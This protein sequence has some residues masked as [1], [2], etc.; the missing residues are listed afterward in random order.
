MTLAGGTSGVILSAAGAGL[1]ALWED[2]TVP[3]AV[4]LGGVS[5][6]YALHELE[7]IRLPVPGRDWQVPADWVRNGFY[8]SAVIFGGT[9]GFGVFTRV[10][11]AS[12]PI[13]FAWLFVS[14]NIAYG[15]LAGLVYGAMRAVSIYASTATEGPEELVTLNRTIMRLA[16][17]AHQLTGLMLAAFAGY[18][19][20]GPYL[21]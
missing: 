21:A 15:A 8:R 6:V 20:L 1:D 7:F 3:L 5:L 10:P 17:P 4:A 18:L 19:L 14:G 11:Y 9:V 12:L 2:A 16:G 13:L